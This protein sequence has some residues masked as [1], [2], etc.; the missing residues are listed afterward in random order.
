MMPSLAT[1]SG[2][3]HTASQDVLTLLVC[4]T[5]KLNVCILTELLTTNPSLAVSGKCVVC[6]YTVLKMVYLHH[7]TAMLAVYVRFETCL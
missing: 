1:S 3:A 4:T 5:F 6:L 2:A 7:D